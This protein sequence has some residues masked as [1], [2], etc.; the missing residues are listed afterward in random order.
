MFWGGAPD[1]YTHDGTNLT[2]DV[3]D[4]YGKVGRYMDVASAM[5]VFPVLNARISYRIF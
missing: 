5:K 2:R 3:E 1:V 4:I